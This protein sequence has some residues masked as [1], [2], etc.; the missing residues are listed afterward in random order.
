VNWVPQ[1]SN[2]LLRTPTYRG[3]PPAKDYTRPDKS[4]MGWFGLL[5]DDQRPE[6]WEPIPANCGC[7]ICEEQREKYRQAMAPNPTD[8]YGDMPI[9]VVMLLEELEGLETR[10]HMDVDLLVNTEIWSALGASIP[11]G[12]DRKA[13]FGGTPASPLAKLWFNPPRNEYVV[14]R[15]DGISDYSVFTVREDPAQSDPVVLLR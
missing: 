7:P 11:V 5:S 15:M 8:H 6:R 12:P 2:I 3:D 4:G 10:M 9:A 1:R 14:E 13:K